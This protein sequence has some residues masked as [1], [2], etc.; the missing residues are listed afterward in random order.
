MDDNDRAKYASLDSGQQDSWANNGRRQGFNKSKSLDVSLEGAA[1]RR[2]AAQAAT[3]KQEE[4]DTN[5]PK[6][7]NEFST[8]FCMDI[9][10]CRIDFY[11]H[12]LGI[13]ALEM[14]K[15]S[16]ICSFSLCIQ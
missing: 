1:S 3:D 15:L 10:A 8:R 14:I 9:Q 2:N 7:R 4:K 12:F 11:I 6:G 16:S 13:F 5:I